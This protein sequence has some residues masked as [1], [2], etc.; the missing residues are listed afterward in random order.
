M[1]AF[2]TGYKRT[3]QPCMGCVAS[4]LPSVQQYFITRQCSKL[5]W[6]NRAHLTGLALD[7]ARLIC[8][9]LVVSNACWRM[10]MTAT[11][12]LAELTEKHRMLERKIEEELARP[13][14]DVSKIKRW[15]HEKLRLKDE[16]AKLNPT[17]H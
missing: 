13:A 10:Q 16:I 8:H 9:T 11:A 14:A 7:N 6:R 4:Q 12:H 1:G 17:R 5:L 15:K 2:D 3:M